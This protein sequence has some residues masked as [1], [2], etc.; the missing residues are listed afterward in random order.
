MIQEVLTYATIAIALGY[1]AYS[2]FRILVPPKGKKS[3]HT[4]AGCN[5]GCGIVKP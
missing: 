4:C 1:F 3:S 5:G 2:I